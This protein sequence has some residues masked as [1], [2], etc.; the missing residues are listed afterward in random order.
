MNGKSI[1]IICHISKNIVSLNNVRRKFNLT[2]GVKEYK[3]PLKISSIERTTL[4][5]FIFF[6]L[7]SK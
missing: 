3:N 2:I 6:N 1:I 7:K 5:V 4:N